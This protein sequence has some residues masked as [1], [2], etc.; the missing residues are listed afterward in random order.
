MPSTASGFCKKVEGEGSELLPF[1]ASHVEAS[2]TRARD[3]TV[4][5]HQT[6]Y[7]RMG[8]AIGLGRNHRFD[9]VSHSIAGFCMQIR[10]QI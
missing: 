5:L 9:A 3:L 10:Q 7:V 2:N 4:P 1:Q 8:K 6:Q